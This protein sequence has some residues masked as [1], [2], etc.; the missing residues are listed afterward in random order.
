MLTCSLDSACVQGA[1]RP[2]LNLGT[3]LASIGVLLA[4]PNPDDGLMAEVVRAPSLSH[5]VMYGV[6]QLP[7]SRP[8][9]QP[10]SVPAC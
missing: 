4:N 5:C 2:A 9:D 8:A 6:L 1:W 10:V 3:V 7:V